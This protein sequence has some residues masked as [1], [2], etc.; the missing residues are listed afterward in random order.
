M[1]DFLVVLVASVLLGGALAYALSAW[2]RLSGV[3]MSMHGYIAL[4]IGVIL[5][6]ALA[7]GLMRLVFASARR[8]DHLVD[9]RDD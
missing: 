1:R 3:E 2:L 4:G 6:L 8:H 9:V 7:G 5:T